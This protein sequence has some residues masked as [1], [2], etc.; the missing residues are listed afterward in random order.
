MIA[1]GNVWRY[2]MAMANSLTTHIRGSYIFTKFLVTESVCTRKF[3]TYEKT[4]NIVTF[5]I[6]INLSYFKIVIIVC[7][8]C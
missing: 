6:I 3:R 8:T 1:R 4:C 5:T 2:P 7:R